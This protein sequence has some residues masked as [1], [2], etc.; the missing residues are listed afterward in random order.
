MKVRFIIV[1]LWVL[2]TNSFYGQCG[3]LT[4]EID[5]STGQNNIGGVLMP[6][7]IN[8]P[9]QF[10]EHGTIPY[11]TD[12]I[13]RNIVANPYNQVL[14]R[15]PSGSSNSNW[16]NTGA[17]I[18]TPRNPNINMQPIN[19]RNASKK[20]PFVMRRFFKVTRS[21]QYTISGK[22]RCDE[23]GTLE[24][25]NINGNVLNTVNSN[26]PGFSIDNQFNGSFNLSR[27]IYFLEARVIKQR[28]NIGGIL[29]FSFKGKI[30]ASGDWLIKYSGSNNCF[31]MASINIQKII[32]NNCNGRYELIDGVGDNNWKYNI[33][34]NN[35]LIS[36]ITSNSTGLAVLHGLVDGTYKITELP[37]NGYLN[38][39]SERT[40]TINLQQP[41]YV[42]S[43]SC[44]AA[45]GTG[46]N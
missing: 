34:K 18:V 22:F 9:D 25:K 43:F 6:V 10:W 21:A 33:Y 1:I 14:W 46:G 7:P 32:D 20:M 29:S 39:L 12:S 31:P 26:N 38:G 23:Y 3:S 11:L 19:L 17:P 8:S 37:Q 36:T 30:T 27:G 35:I 13:G 41:I 40:V 42:N 28:L 16:N 24:L 2:N 45:V 15:I 5:L 44:F 4:R